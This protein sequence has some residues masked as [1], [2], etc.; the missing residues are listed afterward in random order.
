MFEN[1][2]NYANDMKLTTIFI[3][4]DWNH[5]PVFIHPNQ[6]ILADYENTKKFS[7][8]WYYNGLFEEYGVDIAK[9][10]KLIKSNMLVYELYK[11]QWMTQYQLADN[12]NI[13]ARIYNKPGYQHVNTTIAI[14]G[15]SCTVNTKILKKIMPKIMPYVDQTIVVCGSGLRHEWDPYVNHEF[16]YDKIDLVDDGEYNGLNIEKLLKRQ[17]TLLEKIDEANKHVDELCALIPGCNANASYDAKR[18]FIIENCMEIGL[19][20]NIEQAVQLTYITTNPKILLIFDG[21]HEQLEQLKQKKNKLF[22]CL[23]ANNASTH[24]TI[25]STYQCEKCLVADLFVFTHDKVCSEY[26]EQFG[27]GNDYNICNKMTFGQN[28]IFEPGL[29]EKFYYMTVN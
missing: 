27:N 11:I 8:N 4:N 13:I 19:V 12:D 21:C 17:K 5:L 1:L 16:I 29:F 14:V 22:N 24:L 10:G 23:L 15:E 20:A 18:S 6:I 2:F 3:C 7:K 9:V 26:L 28:I 25:L